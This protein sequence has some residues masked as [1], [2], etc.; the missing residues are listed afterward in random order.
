MAHKF[1]VAIW[2]DS[3]G[4]FT[5]YVLDGPD[6]HAVD[7]SAAGV[8][9]QLEK[10]LAW[11]GRQEGLAPSYLEE[12]LL[13]DH[14]VPIRPAY[15]TGKSTF[16]VPQTFELRVT[17]VHG[18]RPDGTRHC[19]LPTLGLRFSYQPG[20]PVE[21]LLSES[22]QQHLGR[23]TPQQLSRLLMPPRLTLDAVYIRDR[24]RAMGTP[25][26][27][28]PAIESVADVFPRRSRISARGTA[29]RDAEVRRLADQLR[30]SQASLLLLGESGVGKSTVLREA[31]RT[32][33]REHRRSQRRRELID[34]TPPRF[35]SSSGQR[36]IAGMKYLGQWEQRC[37]QVIE[38]LAEARGVLCFDNLLE[39]VRVGSGSDASS[40]VAAFLIPYAQRGEIRIVAE[41]TP[42]ELDACR[43]LLPGLADV[44]EILP[45]APLSAAQ[46]REALAKMLAEARR[47]LHLVVDD[48]VVER[49]LQLFRRFQPYAALP[50]R[51]SRFVRRLIDDAIRD[52]QTVTPSLVLSKFQNDTGLPDVVL[53]DEQ[54][55]REAEVLQR[56]RDE[57]LGQ[58][59]AC[60]A[61]TAV[62]MALKTGLNDPLRPLGVLLFCGPTGVGK[63]ELSK[64]LARFLFGAAAGP[65][66]LVRLDM[67]EY[68]G[69]GS[70]HRLLVA[71]DGQVSDFIRR[72]RRQPFAVVLLDEIEKAAGEV[73]D[74]LLGVLDEGRLTDRFGRTT[75][76][77]SAVLV[78]TSNLG[79]E[80]V[81]TIGFGGDTLPPFERI[82]LDTFRPEFVNRL[83]RI[84]T[85]QPLSHD[86]IRCLA[87][88]ELTAIAQ[89]AGFRK[90]RLQL[91]WNDELVE[92]IMAAGYAPQLGARP[93]LRAVEQL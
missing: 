49:V 51:A 39:L 44:F 6:L 23:L 53:R 5:G 30:T 47:N 7:H 58:E 25:V 69:P 84:V 50:G 76:F 11:H 86:T 38:E 17:C 89:R 10:Y 14:R 26:D 41:A 33:L 43:R 77:H 82:A 28:W 46:A 35:W 85:F 34:A 2:Q 13:R 45:I 31:V 88:R 29:M 22:V 64:A 78:M 9:T 48:G 79:A 73:H 67:S 71:P 59:E 32:V 83:D 56:F 81:S 1:S 60:H 18:R 70:A 27:R 12:L 92:R 15:V 55:L 66:R 42:R 72:M 90:A 93:L 8:L 87:E 62:V 24:G 65:D 16:P 74:M 19:V 4:T 52:R 36:L 54:P 61:A 37:E 75:L 80:R 68:A 63:T 40:S 3:G 21:E 91:T 20:E 57:V